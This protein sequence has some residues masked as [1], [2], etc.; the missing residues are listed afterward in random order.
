MLTPIARIFASPRFGQGMQDGH[1]TDIIDVASHIGVEDHRD[2]VTLGGSDGGRCHEE[3]D[4]Q[5]SFHGEAASRFQSKVKRRHGWA[6]PL[7]YH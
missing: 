3:H 2:G 7:F 5:G 4:E 1:G 6:E